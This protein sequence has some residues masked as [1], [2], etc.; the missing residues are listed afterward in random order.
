MLI[1]INIAIIINNKLTMYFV[2]FLKVI[3]MGMEDDSY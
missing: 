3:S 1:T 2:H